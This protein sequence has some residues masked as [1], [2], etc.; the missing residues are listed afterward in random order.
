MVHASAKVVDN[1]LHRN[2]IGELYGLRVGILDALNVLAGVVVGGI[3]GYEVR[4]ADPSITQK[5]NLDGVSN[6]ERFSR[7]S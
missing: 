4:F 7:S 2:V 5:N 3:G 6:R 1:E